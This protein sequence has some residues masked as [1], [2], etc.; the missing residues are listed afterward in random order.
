[1][2]DKVIPLFGKNISTSEDPL[3]KIYREKKRVEEEMDLL[4]LF[5]QITSAKRRKMLMETAK[6]FAA[7]DLDEREKSKK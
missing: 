6:M 4:G 2:D 1:M 7:L 5:K 3:E